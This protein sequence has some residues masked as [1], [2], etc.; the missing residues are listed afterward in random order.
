MIELPLNQL[1]LEFFP[2]KKWS[3]IEVVFVS[4]DKMYDRA[5]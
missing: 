5:L 2:I 1:S 3:D 4:F